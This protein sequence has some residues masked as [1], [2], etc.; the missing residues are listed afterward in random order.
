MA[1]VSNPLAVQM[2]SDWFKEKESAPLTSANSGFLL[3]N[4]YMNPRTGALDMPSLANDSSMNSASTAEVIK[5]FFD[6]FLTN[7]DAEREAAEELRTWQ[8]KQNKIAMDFS[9]EQA[10]LNQLFQSNSAK[11]A[12]AFTSA[13]ADKQM[14]FQ[15]RMSSTAYQR[16]V[17]DLKKAGLNPILA[18]SQGGASSPSGS[19]GTGFS[20]SG[21]SAA[22][23]TSAGAKANAAA[24]D[25]VADVIGI[26]GNVLTSALKTIVPW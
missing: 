14:A 5:D 15:E 25:S 12:M 18:Y 10:A 16:A 8:E 23:V 20:A 9:A 11:E 2:V 19:A 21:S 7:M 26:I 1:S 3:K 22:G 24:V 6:S 4:T 13:E 17:E